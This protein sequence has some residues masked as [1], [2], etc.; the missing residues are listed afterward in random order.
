MYLKGSR[1]LAYIFLKVMIWPTE[2][3]ICISGRY[4]RDDLLGTYI[5]NKRFCLIF[6]PCARKR[7]SVMP[8]VSEWVNAT[9]LLVFGRCGRNTVPGIFRGFYRFLSLCE[10]S[11]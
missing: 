1:K 6:C 3:L 7:P 2:F 10:G 9:V 11:A 8:L 5:I 4:S